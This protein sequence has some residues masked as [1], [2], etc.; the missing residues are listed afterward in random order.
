MPD[1]NRGRPADENAG[2]GEDEE[3]KDHRSVKGGEEDFEGDLLGVL[4]GDDDYQGNEDWRGERDLLGFGP[5]RGI[6]GRAG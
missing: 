5:M 4:E 1:Q 3:H 2:A 6:L